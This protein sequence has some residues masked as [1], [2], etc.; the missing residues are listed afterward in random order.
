MTPVYKTDLGAAKQSY[1]MLNE[2]SLKFVGFQVGN[3]GERDGQILTINRSDTVLQGKVAEFL[4]ENMMDIEPVNGHSIKITCRF[5][6]ANV[7]STYVSN[8]GILAQVVGESSTFLYCIGNFH[9]LE[10]NNIAISVTI[11]N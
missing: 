3:G 8:I 9:S 7:A 5:S 2:K 6:S 10:V 11:N 4:D 1:C